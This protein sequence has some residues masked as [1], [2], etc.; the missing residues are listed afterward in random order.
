[1]SNNTAYQCGCDN[2]HVI[3][4]TAPTSCNKMLSN[5]SNRTQ[6][7]M[8]HDTNV[9]GVISQYYNGVGPSMIGRTGTLLDLP[10]S[11]SFH[12]HVYRRQGLI[13]ERIREVTTI[14]MEHAF[15]LEVK[16]TIINEKGLEFYDQW[17]MENKDK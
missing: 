13:S 10:N 15:N 6:H 5:N 12:N 14:E 8:D 17:L 16:E 7:A 1:M 9:L 11:I 2:C 3:P 4:L